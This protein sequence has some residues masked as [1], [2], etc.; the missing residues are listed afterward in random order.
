MI[1]WFYENEIYYYCNSRRSYGE[2]Q[3]A[4]KSFNFASQVQLVWCVAQIESA[5]KFFNSHFLA[6]NTGFLNECTVENSRQQP[7]KMSEDLVVASENQNT[8]LSFEKMPWY[9]FLVKNLL[10]AISK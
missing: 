8:V 5:R 1:T 6:E 10:H 2:V 3:L 4:P 7:A 9:I